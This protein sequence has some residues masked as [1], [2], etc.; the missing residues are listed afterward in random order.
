L[1]SFE[2]H[3]LFQKALQRKAW[4]KSQ[5]IFGPSSSPIFHDSRARILSCSPLCY[6]LPCSQFSQLIPVQSPRQVGHCVHGQARFIYTE[7]KRILIGVIGMWIYGFRSCADDR[8]S[9]CVQS[10]C[11]PVR[12]IGM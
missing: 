5:S 6:F 8:L 10:T 11:G 12:L 2:E 9:I 4:Q 7:V 3:L 1:D